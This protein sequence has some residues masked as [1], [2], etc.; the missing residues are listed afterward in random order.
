MKI[1]ILPGHSIEEYDTLKLWSELGYDCFSLGSYIIPSQPHDPKRPSI[2]APAHPDLK[3]IVD[4]LGTP[5]NLEA[6]KRHLPDELIEWTDVISVHAKE[7]DWIIPQWNRIKH[8]RVVWRT[9]GQSVENNERNI[10]PLRT[11]GLQIVR[12]SPKERNI[13]GFAGEDAM[14]RFYKD[15]DEWNGWTGEIAHVI[16]FTQ[17]LRQRDPY[18]NWGFWSE[19]TRG[20]PVVA[21][22]PGSEVIGGDG[23]LSEEHMRSVLQSSRAYL[24][25]G[26]QPASYTLGLIEAMMTG[27]PVVSIGPAWMEVFPYGPQLFE[28]HEITQHWSNSTSQ[29]KRMLDGLLSN[30]EFATAWSV[31]QRERAIK[32]FGK[33]KIAAQWKEFLD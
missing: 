20:L 13:P 29:A 28:G 5:D 33:Q 10:A 3:A 8:K 32:L 23:E 2:A 12:Y 26:T 24:Y 16:N 19:A 14:I 4:A 17:H 27:I 30:K 18:T 22:G 6:A 7:H 25:T 15:P 1:L 21:F 9:I 11:D 31:A